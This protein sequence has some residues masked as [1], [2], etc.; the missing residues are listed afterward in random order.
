MF[1]FVP[2]DVGKYESQAKQA[3]KPDG[4]AAKRVKIV[5]PNK[6][7]DTDE[8]VDKDASLNDASSDEDEFNEAKVF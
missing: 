6:V 8:D 1:C 3:A 7:E 4:T 5:E 2:C